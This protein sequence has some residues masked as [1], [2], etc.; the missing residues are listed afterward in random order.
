MEEVA[1]RKKA[2]MTKVINKDK[3]MV[4]DGRE[5]VQSGGSGNEKRPR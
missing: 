4:E 5:R 1:A 2:K 3:I